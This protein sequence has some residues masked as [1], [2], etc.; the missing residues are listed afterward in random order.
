MV[1][2]V[3]ELMGLLKLH[4]ESFLK[5]HWKLKLK[6]QVFPQDVDSTIFKSEQTGQSRGTPSNNNLDEWHE[7]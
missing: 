2:K 6:L 7:K 4:I 1:P 5:K 3:Y